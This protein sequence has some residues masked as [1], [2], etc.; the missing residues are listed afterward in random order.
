[1]PTIKVNIEELLIALESQSESG[2]FFLDKNSG[3]IFVISDYT[4]DADARREQLD[5]EPDRFLFIPPIASRVG[6]NIM[7][8]FVQSL[9][10]NDARTV[11]ERA[12]DGKK[13]FRRF[14]D[15]LLRY[16]DIREQ[17]FTHHA[18][19]M[20]EIARDWLENNSVEYIDSAL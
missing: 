19:R 4:D 1:M 11:L 17:W 16:P 2:E 18:A 14:K 15:E 6:W 8:N 7:D 3:E 20:T 9:K 5:K 10:N 13:P 12:L